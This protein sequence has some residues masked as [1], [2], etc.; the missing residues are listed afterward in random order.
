MSFFSELRAHKYNSLKTF[1]LYLMILI[2]G[3]N[4]AIVGVTLLDL[5]VV[6]NTTLDK[7]TAIMP[8]NGFASDF[9]DIQILL[10]IAAF[11]TS[12]SNAFIP[13]N[14]TL[15][16]LCVNRAISGFLGGF[17]VNG[18][19]VWILHLWGTESPPF[20]QALHFAFGC[21]ALIGP[22]IAEPFLLEIKHNQHSLLNSTSVRAIPQLKVHYPY[23]IVAS[24]S[25]IVVIIFGIVYFIRR[26]N[27]P[28]PTRKKVVGENEKS[29]VTFLMHC[30]IVFL[31]CS[32][33]FFY[34]GLELSFG[35][36]LTTYVVNSDLKLDKSTA[37]YMTSVYWATFTFFR[38]FTIFVIDYIGCK[39]LLISN[40]FL[41]MLSN[42]I[43]LPFGNSYVW[44]LW[45]GII[46]MGFGTSP[47]F[48]A[49]FGFLQEFIFISSKTASTLFVAGCIGQFVIPYAIGNFVDKYPPIFLYISF[50]CG[51]IACALF[52]ILA[53]IRGHYLNR[54]EETESTRF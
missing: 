18:G 33:L 53:F 36:M 14:N 8:S 52:T 6:V 51:C 22:L 16:S 35:T 19:N 54:R 3:M 20:I 40:L 10:I 44:C 31:S 15:I 11:L 26:S 17:I 25:L 30:V 4:F 50:I 38:C 34:I 9:I 43:L 5:Q 7:I 41:I 24:F 13:W 21:G 37:S 23:M 2:S 47:I 39:N 46:L 48:G 27:D 12:I 42:F 28:H 49:F 1:V 29:S 45:I 32:F